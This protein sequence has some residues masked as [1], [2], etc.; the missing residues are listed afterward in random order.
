M[1]RHLAALRRLLLAAAAGLAVTLAGAAAAAEEGFG[2]M[3]AAEV[4]KA[5]GARDL[6]VFDANGAESYAAGHVPGARHL[7][8]F[9]DYP[10]SALPADKT[11]RLVFYCRNKL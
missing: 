10:A 7:E 1:P 4:A 9:L 6:A 3:P 11:T 2:L 8:D 5:L